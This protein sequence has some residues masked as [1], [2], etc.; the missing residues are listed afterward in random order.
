[1]G[2]PLGLECDMLEV[3]LSKQR[4]MSTIFLPTGSELKVVDSL[5]ASGRWP[6][7]WHV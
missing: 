1:M 7:S 2:E 6:L 5:P 3:A 4:D